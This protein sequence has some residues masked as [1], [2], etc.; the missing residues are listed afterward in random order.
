MENEHLITAGQTSQHI[1]GEDLKS[2]VEIN[3]GS[4]KEI[5]TVCVFPVKE[6]KL[7]ENYFYHYS[8]SQY[9]EL[10]KMKFQLHEIKLNKKED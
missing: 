1:D 6:I 5:K 2:V 9:Q 8:E 7:K 4:T 3:I 10:C